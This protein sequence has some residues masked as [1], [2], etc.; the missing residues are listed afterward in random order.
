MGNT[1]KRFHYTYAGLKRAQITARLMIKAR[2]RVMDLEK[3]LE[4]YKQR[5]LFLFEVGTAIRWQDR[6]DSVRGILDLLEQ[7]DDTWA[8]LE[9][10]GKL[11][12]QRQGRY[13]ALK[14]LLQGRIPEDIWFKV[15][16]YGVRW[17]GYNRDFNVIVDDWQAITRRPVPDET[18]LA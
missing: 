14:T 16:D 9:R 2:Q 11:I 10:Q 3:E 8:E 13:R 4:A 7:R 15:G 1:R 6:G 5:N 18:S 12:D 17:Y